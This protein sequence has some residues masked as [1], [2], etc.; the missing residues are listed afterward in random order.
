[1]S[2]QISRIC[3]L[4]QKRT[5]SLLND[6]NSRVSSAEV[7]IDESVNDLYH[8]WQTLDPVKDEKLVAEIASVGDRL[9][10][11]LLSLNTLHK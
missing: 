9:N 8:M 11:I 7:L 3:K 6:I 10:A 5:K 4:H 1:M 2:N